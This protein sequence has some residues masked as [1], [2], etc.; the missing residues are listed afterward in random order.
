M[1]RRATAGHAALRQS[2][3]GSFDDPFTHDVVAVDA[4][5][6]VLFKT[7][8]H[9][10]EVDDALTRYGGYPEGEDAPDGVDHYEV[11]PSDD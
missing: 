11:R 1:A 10:D 7:A 3:H 4:D 6:N 9:P 5:G 2:E 8:L